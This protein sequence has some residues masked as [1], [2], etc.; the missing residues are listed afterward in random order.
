MLKDKVI[1]ISF[2]LSVALLFV[3]ALVGA[4]GLPESHGPL[5]IRFNQFIEE[6]N[7]VGDFRTV[8]GLGLVTSFVI[9]I[10]FLLA[11]EIYARE[12]LLSYI[13]ASAALIVSMLFLIAVSGIAA[14]N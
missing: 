10:N 6:A 3:S 2:G 13:F 1:V 5:V 9:V 7:L 14:V 4:I 8:F 11:W 12:R